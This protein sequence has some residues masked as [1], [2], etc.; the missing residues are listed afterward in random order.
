M[1]INGT[2]YSSQIA[3]LFGTTSIPA[4]Q[5]ISA[6]ITLANLNV[7]GKVAFTLNGMDANGRT[8]SQQLSVQFQGLQTQ[9]TIAGISN[10]ASGQQVFAP[11]EIISVYGTG[12]GDFVQSAGALP[13]TMFLAGFEASV[14]GNPAYLY[15]VSPTQVNLQIPYETAPG[16]ATLTVG[17]PYA[18]ATYDFQLSATAPGIFMTSAGFLNPS[19]SAAPGETVTLYVTGVGQLRPAIPDGEAPTNAN[20]KPVQ[21]VSLTVGGVTAVTSYVGVPTWSVSVLQINFVV[22]ASAAPGKQPVVVTVGGA[23]SQTAYINI[24]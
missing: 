10:A 1:T 23:S 6:Q 19:S 15:Y 7:P 9:V 4:H 16:P 5:S 3:S 22:P 12:L 13:L 20:S 24:T 2:D 8:W 17:N 18:N 11:G 14:N 21:A